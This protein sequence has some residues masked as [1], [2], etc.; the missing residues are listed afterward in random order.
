MPNSR[1]TN[2][3]RGPMGSLRPIGGRRWRRVALAASA[4]TRP[5]AT[6]AAV[7]ASE[8]AR[9]IDARSRRLSQLIPIFMSWGFA[10]ASETVVSARMA[11]VPRHDARKPATAAPMRRCAIRSARPARRARTRVPW[12]SATRAGRRRRQ[13]GPCTGRR[14]RGTRGRR[15]DRPGGIGSTP[16]RPTAAGLWSCSRQCTRVSAPGDRCPTCRRGGCRTAAACDR[17]ATGSAGT[18]APIPAAGGV[19]SG[20]DSRRQVRRG[21]W[22]ARRRHQGRRSPTGTKGRPR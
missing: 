13:E 8:A 11:A 7:P 5:P 9:R 4:P 14:P 12:P 20:R 21:A 22:R 16:A 3:G 2:D 1:P 17:C 19:P 6:D 18:A 15:R 10:M